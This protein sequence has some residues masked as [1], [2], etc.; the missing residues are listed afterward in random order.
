[1]NKAVSHGWA[2][3]ISGI[4][5]FHLYNQ[6]DK[7][8]SLKWVAQWERAL[9][10]VLAAVQAA[11]TLGPQD[12]AHPEVWEVSVVGR[13]AIWQVTMGPLKF[14]G[15]VLAICNIKLHIF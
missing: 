12:R 15:K 4:S 6:D 2:S 7:T 11:L 10:Q 3:S 5:A 14:G 13:D 8:V 9:L 1:M